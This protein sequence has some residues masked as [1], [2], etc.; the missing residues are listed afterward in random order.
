[1]SDRTH[2]SYP[3][4]A[5]IK[6]VSTTEEPSFFTFSVSPSQQQVTAS[7]LGSIPSTQRQWSLPPPMAAHPSTPETPKPSL[8]KMPITPPQAPQGHQSSLIQPSLF[9]MPITPPQGPQ[10]QQ[11]PQGPQTPKGPQTPQTPQTHQSSLIQPSM[12]KMPITPERKLSLS[13]FNPVKSPI[14][15]KTPFFLSLINPQVVPKAIRVKLYPQQLPNVKNLLKILS[16][17]YY[18]CDESIMGAGKTHMTSS[19]IQTLKPKHVIIICTA[20]ALV[21]TWK[22]VSSMYGLPVKAIMSYESFSSKR[23]GVL[24]HGLLFGQE[25]EDSFSYAPT[26]LMV[27]YLNEGTFFVCDETMKIKNSGTNNHKAVSAVV[28]FICTR[29]GKLSNCLSRI[30]FLSASPFDKDI[31]K[32]G[33]MKM[34]NIIKSR[35]L[36]HF[37]H[38]VFSAIGADEVLSCCRKIDPETT[39]TIMLENPFYDKRSTVNTCAMLFDKVITMAYS[40]AAPGSVAKDVKFDCKNGYYNLSKTRAFGLE[41]SISILNRAIPRKRNG[42]VASSDIDWGGVQKAL[43][44]LEYQK[45]DIFARIAERDLENNPN[46]KVVIMVNYLASIA[47]LRILLNK[48]NPLLLSGSVSAPRRTERISLFQ[49]HNLNHRVLICNLQVGCAGIDLDDTHGGFPRKMLLSPGYKA[50]SI[51]QATHRVYR[52]TTKSDASIRFIFGKCG[53]QET[54]I[55]NALS[56]AGSKMC[57][58]V[59]HQVKLGTN[60]IKF[61]GDYDQE[62]EV[63]MESTEKI[64]HHDYHVNELELRS[65]E[66]ITAELNSDDRSIIG[67]IKIRKSK[68][69][70]NDMSSKPIDMSTI[71]II[72][73]PQKTFFIFDTPPS[74]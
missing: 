57:S 24:P 6:S 32:I 65:I 42:D 28:K 35:N 74:R 41:T 39:N 46:C 8:F 38:G 29:Y 48:Y 43:V 19:V 1:M 63:N 67:P 70:L 10:G 30:I 16:K 58:S 40:T 2:Q 12:F 26:E 14:T 73:K 71:A 45:I 23:L 3:H 31:Q 51:H 56:N 64:I 49:E 13:D 20:G 66:E 9:K 47:I 62:D 54:S 53:R 68:E 4:P 5:L 11:T 50:M 21:N 17:S 7:T 44:L 22:S 69:E 25:V 52:A 59:P 37:N 55:L 72:S 27:Q 34:V 33:F 61:P 15:P 18:A 36:Y 60:K